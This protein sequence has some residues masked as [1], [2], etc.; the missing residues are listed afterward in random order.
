MFRTI[1]IGLVLVVAAFWAG[2]TFNVGGSPVLLRLVND[3]DSGTSFRNRNLGLTG[4]KLL[5]LFEKQVLT[6]ESAEKN[7]NVRVSKYYDEFVKFV[8]KGS[9]EQHDTICFPE[10]SVISK[11]NRDVNPV[12]N[13][14]S[15]NDYWRNLPMYEALCHGITSIE[16]DVWLVNNSTELAVG[17]NKGFLDPI[18][19]NLESLYTGPLLTMLNEVN[20][21]QSEHNDQKYG[22]FYNSPETTV[23]LYIDFKSE[24]SAKTYDLLINR[25][26]APLIDMG[27]VTYLDIENQGVV[28]NPLTI[29][30]TGDYPTDL[31]VLDGE[32]N[33]GILHTNQ[34]FVF[35]DAPLHRLEERHSTLSLVA[36]AS[37]SQLLRGCKDSEISMGLG[38]SSD[39]LQCIV[40]YIERAHSM[41]LKTRIWGVPSWPKQLNTR[42]LGQQAFDLHVD[43]LNVDDLYATAHLF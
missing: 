16:A 13:V 31:G 19:R 23:Y 3:D 27:Y 18:H 21:H 24:D 28:W 26:L 40:P 14:H 29:I 20:C 35:I 7:E 6:S 42:L 36:S 4:Y 25:Y 12:F 5:D 32:Q 10:S 33:D 11:L 1:L 41:S 37:L 8:T 43:F 22:L 39:Q 17:H 38:L 34:R 9:A 30:L 15:H 2:A